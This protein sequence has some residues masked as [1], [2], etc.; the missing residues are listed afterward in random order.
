MGRGCGREGV[1]ESV[2]QREGECEAKGE[3]ETEGG[4]G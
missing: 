4:R 1:T 2:R 3:G